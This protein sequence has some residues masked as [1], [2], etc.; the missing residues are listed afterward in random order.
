MSRLFTRGVEASDIEALKVGGDGV[1]V[2]HLQFADDTIL[3]P[4]DDLNKFKK[5]FTLL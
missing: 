4:S 3:F 2:S 5:A 1:V